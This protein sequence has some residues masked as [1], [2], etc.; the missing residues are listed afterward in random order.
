MLKRLVLAS[1]GGW[2]G[3]SARYRL[4]PLRDAGPWPI[5]AVSA[6]SF[7]SSATVDAILDLGGDGAGL[8]LQRTL[9]TADDI[10]RLKARYVRVIFDFDDAIYAVPPALSS[11]QLSRLPKR[12]ARLLLR[13][14]IHASARQG[15]FHRLLGRVDACVAGNSVLAEHARRFTRRVLVIPTTVS[16]LCDASMSRENPP[17]VVWMGLPDNL[18]Y[19]ELVGRALARIH[20]E[21]RFTFRVLST[22]RWDDAPIP[23]EF[24]PWSAETLARDLSSSSVGLAPLTDDPWTRGKCAFRAIQYGGHGL[25]TVASPVGITERVV[26]HGQTGFLARTSADWESA[27]R[28]LLAEPRLVRRMGGAALQHIQTNYSDAVALEAWR[29]LISSLDP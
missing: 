22:H 16:P 29:D 5:E 17:V 1:P 26:I 27:L 28:S 12:A 19:L 20:K 10:A 15:P 14:S 8:I 4:G 7:P 18:Q 9:P 25:P 13:R 3:P 24:V 2:E 6:A 23:V 21:I 11:G